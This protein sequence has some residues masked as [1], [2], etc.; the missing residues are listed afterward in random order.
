MVLPDGIVGRVRWL[1]LHD[2]DGIREKLKKGG[3]SPDV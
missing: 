3:T 1:G 2:V